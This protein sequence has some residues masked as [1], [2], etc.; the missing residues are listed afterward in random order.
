MVLNS[1]LGLDTFQGKS[2]ITSK[3]KYEWFVVTIKTGYYKCVGVTL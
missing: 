3:Q 2:V 1:M